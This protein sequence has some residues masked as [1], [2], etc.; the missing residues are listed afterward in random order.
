VIVLD[1][2]IQNGQGVGLGTQNSLEVQR[3]QVLGNAGGGITAS[4]GF[5][6]INTVIAN[7]G[8]QLGGMYGGVRLVPAPGKPAVFRFNTVTKNVAGSVSPGVQCESAVTLEDSIIHNN[9]GLLSPE[10]GAS[11]AAKY[12]LLATASGAGNN[13]QGNPMF[14]NAASDFHL[15]PASPAID[16]ADPAATELVDFEG[17]G[18]PHGSAR[19][20]GADEQ[21]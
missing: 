16:N 2:R 21:P 18:R 5:T 7:N 3:T 13:V 17:G 6:I 8:T 1:S 20:I 12:C 15:T 9:T 14:V 19:D 10:M 11:C 4:G